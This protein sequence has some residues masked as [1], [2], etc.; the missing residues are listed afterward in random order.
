MAARIIPLLF[1]LL[2]SCGGELTVQSYT[3]L[4]AARLEAASRGEDPDAVLRDAGVEKEEYE[5]FE[6]EVFSDPDLA[7]RVLE[8]IQRDHPELVSPA[9]EK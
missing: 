5:R 4:L 6:L 7:T 8:A 3:D 9:D 1:L 2:V